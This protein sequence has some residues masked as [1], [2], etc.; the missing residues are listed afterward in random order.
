V[1]PTLAPRLFSSLAPLERGVTATLPRIA[2]PPASRH[3][4]CPRPRADRIGASSPCARNSRRHL[5]LSLSHLLSP[6]VKKL[7]PSMASMELSCRCPFTSSRC[8]LPFLSSPTKRHTRPLSPTR[9]P[10][11]LFPAR[12]LAVQRIAVLEPHRSSPEPRPTPRSPCPAPC[13]VNPP[14][15]APCAHKLAQGRR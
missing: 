13:S 1:G 2:R 8:P 15:Q 9:A 11:S 4:A 3:L 5:L 6:L 12:A 7:P 10:S 14:R